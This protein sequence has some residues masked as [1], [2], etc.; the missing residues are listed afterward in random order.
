MTQA[1]SDTQPVSMPTDAAARKGLPVVTGFIDYFPDAVL[2]VAAVSKQGNDQHNP[3]QPLH[4]SREKSSDHADTAG[5]HMMER[6]K[7]DVDGHRHTAKWAWRVMALLQLEIE[8]ARSKPAEAPSNGWIAWGGGKCPVSD[9]AR[10]EYIMR[11][12]GGVPS[13]VTT[14]GGLRWNHTGS[15]GDV[16]AYR[17]VKS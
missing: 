3:G 2:A 8:A 17:V 5:R 14:A 7:I 11:S 4:W 6:G 16:V 13:D 9:V 15:S 10:V 1:M 12:S